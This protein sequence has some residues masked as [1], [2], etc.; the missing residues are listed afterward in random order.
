MENL[1]SEDPQFRRVQYKKLSDNVR[2]W[3]QEISALVAERLPK[4]LGLSVT[5]VFQNV[6][7]EKGYGVGTAI[8][9]DGSSG[10]QVGIPIVIKAWHLAP[11]DLFFAEGKLYPLTDDN[12]AKIFYQNSLGAGVATQKPPPHMADDVFSDARNP[13]LGGKYSYSAPFS[14][15]NLISGTLGAKDIAMFKQA[16]AKQPELLAGFH[17]RGTF[18]ILQKYAAEDKPPKPGEQDRINKD[19]AAKTFTI[20]KDGPDAYRLYSAPDEVYDPSMVTTDRQGLKNW[21]DMRR[22]ELWDYENDPL[23]SVDQYGH[24]TLEPPK[25]PY[26]TDVDGPA[27]SGVDGSGSYGAK[28]GPHKNP[29]VF[30]PRQDDRSVNT[31][32]TFGRYAVRDRDG[33]LAKGWVVPNVVSFDGSPVPTK[34]FL[35][36]A[37]ASIQGRIS[38]IPLY[39]DDEDV[40]LKPDRA[41]TGKIGT[42]IYRDGDRVM[43]TCPF[44]VTSVT[45]YKNLRSLAVVDYKG[46]C[47]N[48]ILSPN[49]N[50]IVRVA[51]N[52]R[53]EL[54]PLCGTGKNYIVSAKMF[55]VRMPRLCPVSENPDDFKRVALEHLDMNPIKVAQANGKYI[56]RGGAI[57]KY[58]SESKLNF[59]YLPRHEA[60][61]LLRS[62]GLDHEKTAEVLDGTRQHI[63]LEVHH[64]RFP[65]LPSEVKTASTGSLKKL[66]QHLQAPIGEIVKA[67][68]N[69]EDAQ[70]VDSVLG[71]GFINEENVSRFASAK[72]MLWEVSH[73][74]AK[75]LLGARLGMEDIPEEAVRSALVHLQRV[76]EGLGRLKML[77]EHGVKTS[78]AR[79]PSLQGHVGGRLTEAASPV[80]FA[81]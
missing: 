4:D 71:L 41:D 69:L 63:Q 32:S 15:I 72:P 68:A 45:V 26:G 13:P 46:N 3:Q 34:L 5:M 47:C 60:E 81:R 39:D 38:G 50:G 11:I 22:S 74:L 70:T 75:L 29:W 80:G 27:G 24:F 57:R 17:R 67:A 42:L 48:L 54:G 40:G 16:F 64:L 49:V 25:T 28:L 1:F 18:D 33:V 56:F 30:D 35:G 55:F 9:K 79:R 2:E 43:A 62:W 10:K 52:Q 19:R 59:N 76:I 21:L 44:Q 6:D 37:L 78:A 36:K 65:P 23:H 61:F 66:A 58:A 20:K 51:D 8:A 7:E 12:I 14:M 73:M 53:S 77:D 31:I